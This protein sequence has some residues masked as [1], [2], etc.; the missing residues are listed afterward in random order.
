V[1]HPGAGAARPG[2]RELEPR[3]DRA[4]RALLVAEVQVV[5][6]GGVEVDGLLHEAQAEDAGVELDVP[7]RVAGD[8]RDVVHALEL[9]GAPSQSGCENNYI[10]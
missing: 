7:A 3:E 9:H 10:R 4:G 6:V 8:H 2:A 1:D 5:R